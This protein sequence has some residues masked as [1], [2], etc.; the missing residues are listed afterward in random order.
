MALRLKSNPAPLNGALYVSNPRRRK[1]ASSSRR[2]SALAK[3]KKLTSAKRKKSTRRKSRRKTR[4]NGLSLSGLAI[5][6][7]PKRKKRV[8]RKKKKAVSKKR[9]TVARKKRKSTTRK[10][11][12]SSVKRRSVRKNK[13]RVVRKRK[14][15]SRKRRRNPVRKR[16]VSSRRKGTKKGMRRKTARKAYMKKRK[17]PARKRRG[18]K[19]GMR[20][21]TARRA[22]MKKRKNRKNPK[23]KVRI[24]RKNPLALT[25]LQPLEKLVSK[26]PVIGKKIA[27]YTQPAVVAMAGGVSVVAGMKYVSSIPYVGEYAKYPFGHAFGYTVM[28]VGL[29]ALSQVL[30]LAPATKKA[31]GMACAVAGGALNAAQLMKSGFDLDA[32]K[33]ENLEMLGESDGFGSEAVAGLGD[34]MYYEIQ[35][36]SGVAHDMA[37]LDYDTAQLGDACTCPSDLS[38]IEGKAAV[39]G[40]DGYQRTFGTPPKKMAGRKTYQSIMANRQGHR[41]GWL[42]KSLGYQRFK[43]LAQLPPRQRKMLIAKLKAS[44]I[45]A[46]QATFDQELTGAMSGIDYSLDMSGLSVDALSGVA[47]AGA[48][49]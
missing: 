33:Q 37:G 31:I 34:G 49:I 13:K 30:P 18:T 42:I 28:G 4:R 39:L 47:I 43:Q 48:G 45:Q 25:F 26:I 22:Y 23:R 15:S 20:R 10:R 38:P 17:A 5:K 27:P 21:K 35:P 29:A 24:V 32:V 41:W 44:A 19:K 6:S 14:V 9:K 7:N 16:R 2:K 46:S 40:R 8:V 12:T 3:L 11:R 1:K 36:L